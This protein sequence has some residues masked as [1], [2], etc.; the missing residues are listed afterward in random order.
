MVDDTLY[1]IA[2]GDLVDDGQLVVV[3]LAK[4]IGTGKAIAH[5][6]WLER[7]TSAT[8]N[9]WVQGTAGNTSPPALS[10]VTEF[11]PCDDNSPT[12]HAAIAGRC[13]S[14][15]NSAMQVGDLAMG[16][17]NGELKKYDG[18]GTSKIKARYRGHPNENVGTPLIAGEIG[19]FTIITDQ[20]NP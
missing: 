20:N 7:S 3:Q 14:K 13:R 9:Q 15:C 6:K 5:G 8:P 1:G 18:S 19:D 17:A 16:D 4:G 10:N 2:N 12:V 11:N